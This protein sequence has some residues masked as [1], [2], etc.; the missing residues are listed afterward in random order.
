MHTVVLDCSSYASMH[1]QVPQVDA[2]DVL[3]SM[4]QPQ[5]CVDCVL[6]DILRLTKQIHFANKT[7]ILSVVCCTEVCV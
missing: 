7:P 2:V 6:S 3:H 1:M 4:R 5:T